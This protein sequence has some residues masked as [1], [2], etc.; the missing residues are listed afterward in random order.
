M[1]V[2]E[3]IAQSPEGGC[4]RLVSEYGKRLYAAAVMLCKDESAAEDLFFRTLERAVRKISKFSPAGSFYGWLYTIMLNF[5]R[6]DLRK[7]RELPE[8]EEFFAQRMTDESVFVD[9]MIEKLD[10]T[11]LREAV[12]SLSEGHRK[13]LLLRYFEDF[14]VAEIAGILEI[15][16]GTVMS[17]LYNARKSLKKILEKFYSINEG[18]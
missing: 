4:H 14:S 18:G 17:R 7:K 12:A 9:K 5:R 16:E 13:M 2:W 11:V 10:A 8:S 6:M 15:P 3:E 1:D